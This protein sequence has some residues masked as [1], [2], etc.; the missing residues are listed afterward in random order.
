[1]LRIRNLLLR[2]DPTL[3]LRR[4]ASS[5]AAPKPIP[6]AP[7]SRRLLKGASYTALTIGGLYVVDI[8]FNESSIVRNV[9]T[10]WTC[11]LIALDYK[12]NFKPELTEEIPALHQRV[13]DRVYDLLTTNG[14]LYIKMGQAIGNNAALLPGPLQEKFAKLFDDAPQVPYSV[15]ESV[16]K[17]EYGREPAGP[18]G[19]FEIFEEQA[20]ASASVAQVHRA[21][22]KS[23]DGNGEWVAVKVQKPAVS[24]QVEWD[25]GAFHIVMWL[26]EHYLFHMPVYFV[27]GFISDHLRRELDF[28]QEARNALMTGDFIQSEPSLADK[29]Y[30][31]RVYPELSTKKVL[32][33]EWIDGTRLSDKKGV[34][35]LMG[36]GPS[37]N[38][39]ALRGGTKW[40]MDTMVQLFSAQIF[41]WGWVHCDPHPGNI[42]IRGHPL[43]PRQPQFVLLD[44]GLYVRVTET[45]R[46]QYATLWKSLMTMDYD[47]IKDVAGQWGIGT[48]DLFA[49]ATLM[50]PVR[51]GGQKAR[52]KFDNMSQYERSVLIKQR[53]QGF[54]S[55]TDKMPKELVFIGR[56]MRI[57]QGNNQMFGS[58]VNRIRI[59]GSWASKSLIRNPNLTSRQRAQEYVGYLAFLFATFAIDAAFYFTRLKQ[60][61]RTLLGLKSHGFEDELE[62]TMKGFAKSNFGVEI[63]DTAFQG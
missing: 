33:A 20:V 59:T 34:K 38:A 17:A 52:E 49:S 44:H 23:E 11:G 37:P 29:V 35:D 26:Y 21:K 1:M 62:R 9:R 6:R 32:V 63:A 10:L 30:V 46:H 42:L 22:L 36:E 39:A 16:L 28:E 27:A 8:Q 25:L 31:P 50:K 54:L 12:L 58:P 55:D 5:H 15:V 61:T 53:L 24:R 47:T 14:G 51:F 40:I 45:F 7:W 60:W 18:G 57:V 41:S 13:A 2:P 56:N 19:I 4:A 48:P 3:I 43:K